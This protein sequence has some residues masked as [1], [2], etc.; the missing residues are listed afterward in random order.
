MSVQPDGLE[1]IK[2]V[3]VLH[4]DGPQQYGHRA[5]WRHL[6]RVMNHTPRGAESPGRFAEVLNGD[7]LGAGRQGQNERRVCRGGRVRVAGINKF[8]GLVVVAMGLVLTA[9]TQGVSD[10]GR[11]TRGDHCCFLGTRRGKTK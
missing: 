5:G 4:L 8:L 7:E 9:H 1:V 6:A 11:G 10:G 2:L 3:R